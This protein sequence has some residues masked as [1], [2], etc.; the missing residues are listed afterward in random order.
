ME[1]L[2]LDPALKDLPGDPGTWDMSLQWN[3]EHVQGPEK[4]LGNRRLFLHTGLMV[5]G[6]SFVMSTECSVFPGQGPP[7][8]WSFSADTPAWH[9]VPT[10]IWPLHFTIPWYSP[11]AIHNSFLMGSGTCCCR[12][13]WSGQRVIGITLVLLTACLC[14]STK[15]FVTLFPCNPYKSLW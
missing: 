4:G 14:R 13:L 8:T 3:K 12:S 6:F 5:F 15:Q 2:C 9:S 7:V 11:L 10:T 1:W